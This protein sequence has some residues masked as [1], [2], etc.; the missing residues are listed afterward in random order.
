MDSTD[1][2]LPTIIKTKTAFKLFAS[3]ALVVNLTHGSW[4]C[5]KAWRSGGQ[6]VQCLCF[7]VDGRTFQEKLYTSLVK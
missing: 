5:S 6:P 1:K 2:L 3:I 4:F 7:T